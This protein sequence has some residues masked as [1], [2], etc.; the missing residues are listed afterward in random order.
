MFRGYAPAWTD[1]I[2]FFMATTG[3]SQSEGV[4]MLIKT[5]VAGAAVLLLGAC[6]G[7][8]PKSAETICEETGTSRQSDAF[9]ACVEEQERIAAKQRAVNFRRTHP[10]PGGR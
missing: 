3:S 1:P 6:Q 4:N 8:V 5:I 7:S 10:G 9:A 2:S